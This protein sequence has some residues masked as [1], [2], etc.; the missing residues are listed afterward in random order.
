VQRRVPAPVEQALAV[1]PAG[2]WL[3]LLEDGEVPGRALLDALPELVQATDVTHYRV[4][5]RWLYPAPDSYL[6]EPPWRPDYQTRLVLND[7]RL[8]DFPDDPYRS[9]DA[10]GPARY[11]ETPIYRLELLR[12]TVEER[13]AIAARRERLRPGERAA[14]LPLHHA[15]LLPEGREPAT[16]PVPAADLEVLARGG[17]DRRPGPR[18]RPSWGQLRRSRRRWRAE[19]HHPH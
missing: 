12:R 8:L 13:R 14:G 3:L 15:F 16:A 19:P 17:D 2:R 18:T 1:V 6:D 4:P 5:R 10:D 11:L 7:A 9:F